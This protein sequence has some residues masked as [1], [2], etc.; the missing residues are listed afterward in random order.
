[1]Y[2]RTWVWILLSVNNLIESTYIWT[3]IPTWCDQNLLRQ[4]FTPVIFYQTCQPLKNSLCYYIIHTGIKGGQ[5][6]TFNTGERK[7]VHIYC[8]GEHSPTVCDVVNYSLSETF[9]CCWEGKLCFNC[10]GSHKILTTRCSWIS[11]EANSSPSNMVIC[12]NE[13]EVWSLNLHNHQLS[14]TY[15]MKYCKH[16]N[17]HLAKLLCFQPHEAICRNIFAVHWDW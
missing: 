8:K 3:L 16:G 1:M 10:L 15:T 13:Q 6:N 17:F 2:V 7:V 9:R 12:R 4:V 11:M 14:Y 5:S